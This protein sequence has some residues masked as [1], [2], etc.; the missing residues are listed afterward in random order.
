MRRLEWRII[1]FYTRAT[2]KRL[3]FKAHIPT[4]LLGEGKE[5]AMDSINKSEFYKILNEQDVVTD[6]LLRAQ[7]VFRKAVQDKNWARL[8]ASSNT[9]DALTMRFNELDKQ[10]AIFRA[11]GTAHTIEESKLIADIKRKLLKAQIENKAISDYI[12]IT[13]DFV[14]RL[15]DTALPQ[16]RPKLY[17]RRGYTQ[18]QPKSIVLNTLM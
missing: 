9:I 3:K 7:A 8:M 2:N 17:T 4:I 10:G 16:S 13:R 18:A 1:L 14:R 5:C 6:K 15:I 12:K 11:D